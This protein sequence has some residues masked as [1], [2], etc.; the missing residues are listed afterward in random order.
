MK[1]SVKLLIVGLAVAMVISA[2]AVFAADN[3][4][5]AGK[6]V[7]APVTTVSKLKLTQDDATKI[8]LNAHKD[9]KFVS[10]QR[11]GKVYIVKISTA[12]GNRTLNIGG[13]TGK[14]LKDAA[15]V[16]PAA[17]KTA[18]TTATKK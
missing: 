14:I 7:K 3:A 9:A 2:G 18:T 4:K 5:P 13:N 6:T 16:A 12:N 11:S 8:A 1:K 10:A 15:D 17:A